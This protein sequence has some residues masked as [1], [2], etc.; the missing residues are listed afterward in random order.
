MPGQGSLD[1]LLLAAPAS[2]FRRAVV[3]YASKTTSGSFQAWSAG[4]GCREKNQFIMITLLKIAVAVAIGY[5]V[6]NPSFTPT[7]QDASCN[8]SADA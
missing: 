5:A 4:R 8:C 2:G 7:A 3:Y 1:L 6:V